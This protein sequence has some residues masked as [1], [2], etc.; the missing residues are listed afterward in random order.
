M[1]QE[2]LKPPQ[3]SPAEQDGELTKEEALKALKTV[4]QSATESL[5][6]ALAQCKNDEERRTVQGNRDSVELDYLNSLEKSLIET[7]VQ[8]KKMAVDLEAES[9]AVKEKSKKLE[10][11]AQALGLFTGLVRLAA[12]LVRAFV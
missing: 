11:V 1:G 12:S 4:A 8:F 6:A 7:G 2:S 10:N 5:P 3:G 9:E